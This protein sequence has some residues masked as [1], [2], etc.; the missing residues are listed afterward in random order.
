VIA[1]FRAETNVRIVARPLPTFPPLPVDFAG[2][3][4]FAAAPDLAG[5]GPFV[6]EGVFEGMDRSGLGDQ[7]KVMHLHCASNPQ[8]MQ[9]H[10]TGRVPP[11]R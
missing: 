4:D 8:A 1:V 7:C 6:V 2:F 11:P 9:W 5:V 10:C 3:A